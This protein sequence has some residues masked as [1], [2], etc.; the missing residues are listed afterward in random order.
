MFKLNLKI[1][2]RNLWRNKGFTLINLG[3]LAIG[4]ACCLMLLLYVSYEWSYDRQFKNVDRIYQAALNLSVNGK[5]STTFALPNRLSAAASAELPEIKRSARV[6]FNKNPKLYSHGEDHF[7]LIPSYVDPTFLKIFDYHFIYGNANS[8]LNEP[9][10]VVINET[11]AKKLF[12]RENPIGQRITYDGRNELKVSAVIEDL[13]KNQTIQFEV[14]HPW[15]FF[16][17]LN[18]D[19]RQNGWGAI[20][21]MTYFELNEGASLENTNQLLQKFIVNKAPNLADM[22]YQPFL[23]PISKM[24]LY[25]EFRNGK[26][27][28]GRIDQVKL[29]LFLA[30]CVLFIACINYM[31]LSTA[32]SE[33][34]ARE[35][36]VRKALGSSRSTI[37]GQFMIESIMLSLVAI[38]IGFTL[39]EMLLPY[40][41]HL[42]D[43]EIKINYSSAT[44]WTA[45]LG[46]AIVSGLL[47]GSY[48]AFYLSSF[49]PIKVLKGF[50]GSSGSL[51]IR[52]VLVVLQFGLSICMI[53]SAV[54]IYKQIQFMRDKPLGFDV[55]ALAQIDL[56][57]ELL[58]PGKLE[59]LKN[60]LKRSGAVES[61]T[62]YAGSFTFDGNITSDF[63]WPGKP[64]N[65][66]S[67]VSYRSIGF[68]FAH[69]TGV[70]ILTGR[71]FSPKFP[72]DT[73]TSLLLNEE[74]VK[75]MGLKNPVGAAIFWGNEGP[76]KIVGVVK[77]FFNESLGSKV[78]PT[79]YYYNIKQSQSLLLKLS[80]KQS[81]SASIEMIKQISQRINPAY[82]VEIKLV[83][84]GMEEKIQTEKLLSVLSNVFGGFAIFISCLG[85]LGLA[86]YMAEQRS[87]EIS[88]RKVLGAN[89]SDI[90]ML[91]NKDFMKLVIIA[92]IIAIPVAYILISRWL[93]KYD[94]KISISVWPFLFAL[95]T[96]IFIAI[97]TVSLQTFNVA[98]ANA[99]DALK[100]E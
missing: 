36:G 76:L 35:V 28:G 20:T 66:V 51:S 68:N 47:A 99:A 18:P 42:L 3:G 100:Y 26:S 80:P 83:S 73:S 88:I 61:A 64:K 70:K 13:P 2:L 87:K 4:M 55:A 60:E 37:M 23:F 75:L 29:F 5:L 48:P 63:S 50:K 30:F 15:S 34:R 9:G 33:K 32:R 46:L 38:V 53:I 31:N 11:T 86:L 65:D 69:T 72:S 62:E 49:I 54:I 74:A 82:P 1:A 6:S 16:D 25:Q 8:A 58:K 40:F 21:C 24:H 96:S 39:S 27:V 45:L 84:D 44:V 78:S 98:K 91:L 94:Y 43:I 85:L 97:V 71:D 92:N 41:N 59:I 10:A 77:D 56:E 79:V 67:I 89:L 17:Q 12:G 22:T 14:L 52:K 19:D 7:K 93:E 57:G 81:L 90:L 95:L